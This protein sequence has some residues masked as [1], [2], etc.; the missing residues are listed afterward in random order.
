VR[1]VQDYGKLSGR[2][3]SSAKIGVRIEPG[4]DKSYPLD[5]ALWK[6]EDHEEMAWESPW[7]RGRPG[8]HIECSV[9]SNA[10]LGP[11]IDI[12]CGGL[13]LI[14]PHHE[15]EIAQC[16]AHNDVNF[17]NYWVHSGLLN[18][19]GRKMSKSF[20][21]FLTLREALD[22][23]G[24][25]LIKLVVLRHHYRSPINF[26]NELFSDNL[27]FLLKLCRVLETFDKAN[28]EVSAKGEFVNRLV[29]DFEEA[30]DDDFNSPRAI[31]ALQYAIDYVLG[32]A[33]NNLRLSA[34]LVTKIRHLAGTLGLFNP[35]LNLNF[36]E[37]KMLSFQC[38]YFKKECLTR[39]VLID[40][41]AERESARSKR[42]Y[43]RSD[44]IR[45]ELNNLG[46]KLLDSKNGATSWE[47]VVPPK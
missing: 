20:G 2:D 9:M 30:M 43:A 19:N 25:E 11:Q 27:N 38:R 44:H 35:V 45:M 1:K 29:A 42:N 37:S 36:L 21:N 10:L 23:Y 47:F 6:R 24:S 40:K 34:E 7:G 12:H 4:E 14:F 39:E 3:I 33:D 31:T 18:I 15:N 16:E 46:I 26:D 17:V 13:D 41:I 8:W 5:F 32:V 22:E 28:T